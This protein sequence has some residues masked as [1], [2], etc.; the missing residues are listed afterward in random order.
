MPKVITVAGK[1]YLV[2]YPVGALIRAE[3]HLGRPLADL[4]NTAMSFSDMAII[5]RYGLHT[6]DGVPIT[7]EEYDKLIDTLSLEEFTSVFVEV[8]SEFAGKQTEDTGKN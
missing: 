4:N 6:L 3:T 8:T 7:Q 5:S 2:R 1:E